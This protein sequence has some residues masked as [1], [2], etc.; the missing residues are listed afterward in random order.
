MTP[1]PRSVTPR[2]QLLAQLAGLSDAEVEALVRSL[3]AKQRDARV[4]EEF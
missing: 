1:S 2:D 4:T 3:Q